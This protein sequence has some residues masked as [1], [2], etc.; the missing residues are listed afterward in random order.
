LS[1]GVI[2][3]ISQAP[4]H[5]R[6]MA[7]LT[8][9][10]LL[11]EALPFMEITRQVYSIFGY[12]FSVKN[13]GLP[14]CRKTRSMTNGLVLISE[15]EDQLRK[16]YPCIRS[17]HCPRLFPLPVGFSRPRETCILIPQISDRIGSMI[18]RNRNRKWHIGDRH[19]MHIFLYNHPRNVRILLLG[20]S[21]LPIIKP[22]KHPHAFNNDAIQ[23]LRNS[24][25]F[26]L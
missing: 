26:E 1:G 23:T 20:I 5:C 13:S 12:N 6:D 4:R 19:P 16:R 21:A 25:D 11:A 2:S 7:P 8:M 22:T 17:R 18:G 3:S 15:R 9:Q 24:Y 10:G 14:S